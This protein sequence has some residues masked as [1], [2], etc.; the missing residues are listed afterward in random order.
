MTEIE[1]KPTESTSNATGD[2]GADSVPE[3]WKDVWSRPGRKYRVRAVLLLTINILLFAGVGS[4]AF[5]L[6]SGVAFAPTMGAYRDQLSRTFSFVR[7]RNITLGSWLIEPIN[8]QDVPMQIPILG[9]LMAA[10]ISIPILV[11]IL[12]RFWCCLPFTAIVG[13][14]AVMPWLAITLTASCIIAAIRPL[15]TPFRF[16]SALLGLVPCVVYLFLASAGTSEV[17]AGRMDPVDSIKFVAPWVF[18]IVAAALV[19]AVVLI[20]AKWVDY[21]TGAI[22]PLLAVMFGLPVF[23]FEVYVGRDELHYRLL[24]ALSEAHFEDVDAS[25][26]LPLAAQRAW[27]RHPLPRPR[28]QEVYEAEEEKWQMALAA[29]VHPFE[30]ELVRHQADLVRRCEIFQ[31]TFPQSVYAAS[32][33][34]L[35]AKALDTRVD[36]GEFHRTKW[37]RYYDDFPSCASTLTWRVLAENQPDSSIGAVARLRLAQLELRE[38]DV[39]RAVRGLE[40][41]LHHFEEG[42]MGL[43]PDSKVASRAKSV[44]DRDAPEASLHVPLKQVFLEARRLQDLCSRNYDSAHGVDPLCGPK[45]RSEKVWFGL[46]DLDP[47]HERYRTNLEKLLAQ[48]PRCQ[49]AD[50]LALEIA[51]VSDSVTSRVMFLEQVLA[52]FPEG[53]AVPEALF[54]LGVEYKTQ[55]REERCAAVFTRLQ[56]DYA[57]SPWA[58]LASAYTRV[59]PRTERMTSTGY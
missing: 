22:T 29:D 48:Y 15:R 41:M 53:D 28:W 12:Y 36:V 44:L 54:R 20:I 52:D 1:S 10:L 19:F 33:L 56:R 2:R 34:F 11:A 5:W 47:R 16:V 38:G 6:R 9:L 17:V 40:Q 27:D 21:R 32:A 8:V 59:H 35:Q 42:A 25:A 24:E 55:G 26:E 51:K 31:K 45:R 18:A 4:F 57:Q 23:L 50:N 14:L 7:G 39:D 13:L 30:S 46:A 43:G 58:E 3:A 37:I 49:L